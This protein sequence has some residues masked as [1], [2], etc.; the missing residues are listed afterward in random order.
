MTVGLDGRV[1]LGPFTGDTTYCAGL[2]KGLI[3]H[4]DVGRVVLFASEESKQPALEHPKLTWVLVRRMPGWL[5]TAFALP[6]LCSRRPVDVLH[7][8]YISPFSSPCPVITT[9]HD[10]S[11]KRFPKTFP[12]KDRFLLNTFLPIT[13]RRAARVITDSY[14]SLQ[15]L[16]FFL[17]LAPDRLRAIPLAASESF[18]RPATE[19]EKGR[20][21]RRY[22]LPD[23]YLLFVGVLQPRKNLHR[24]LDAYALVRKKR[25]ETPPLVIVG[26]PGWKCGDLLARLSVEEGVFYKGYVD[27]E[28]LPA[29]YQQAILLVY[30]SLWEGFGLPVLEAMAAGVPV[31]TS[32][33]CAL[34]EIG[35]PAAV[36]VNPEEVTDIADGLD[37]LLSD[38]NLRMK[39][40]EKGVQRASQFSWNRVANMTVAVYKEVCGR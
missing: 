5:F 13:A 27:Q 38:E 31:L 33:R 4:P 34:R 20:V 26:K 18:F 16:R 37:T 11:W 35:Q 25:R 14:C 9:I 10:A 32:N 3:K 7:V 36:L 40:T 30:P 17:H 22:G 15:D 23:S 6:R 8:Q 19:S 24:L 2:V 21:R 1:L 39:S 29:V 28:D 12:P